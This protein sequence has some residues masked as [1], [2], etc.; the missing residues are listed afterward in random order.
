MSTMSSEGAPRANEIV[1]CHATR[2]LRPRPELHFDD[3]VDRCPGNRAADRARRPARRATARLLER[4][5]RILRAC[6][7]SVL[8]A[9]LDGV[10]ARSGRWPRDPWLRAL[11][12][13]AA[14]RGPR[15]ARVP[16]SV[17][18]SRRSSWTSSAV[19]PSV[20]QVSRAPDRRRPAA[21][22]DAA[23]RAAPAHRLRRPDRL[24]RAQAAVDPRQARVK[25]RDS[26]GLDV[27]GLRTDAYRLVVG[28][29]RQLART[30][31]SAGARHRD[32][33]PIRRVPDHSQTRRPAPHALVVLSPGRSIL[34]IP[35]GVHSGRRSRRTRSPARPLAKGVDPE[36][37][38]TSRSRA[39]RTGTLIDQLA[40]R[41]R[42]SA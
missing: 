23:C 4:A 7:A 12:A 5:Q 13:P 1:P 29:R 11:V 35:W 25:D 17:P 19:Q 41:D 24:D 28:V 36:G 31:R 27:I 9:T 20:P 18:D 32:A 38:G 15:P 33:R 26:C 6:S 34:P 16:W 10:G 2:R 22:V 37:T 14:P 21:R 30:A 42:R 3:R 39:L 40:R 8:T